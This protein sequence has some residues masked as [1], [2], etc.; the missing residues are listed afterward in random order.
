MWGML[1]RI[2]GTGRIPGK[3]K[4]KASGMMDRGASPRAVFSVFTRELGTELA[5][6]VVAVQF[7]HLGAA[8]RSADVCEL[9]RRRRVDD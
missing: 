1:A 8:L 2:S 5:Q 9:L 6:D 7:E 3:K 4:R